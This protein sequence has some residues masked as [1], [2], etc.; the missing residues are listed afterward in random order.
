MTTSEYE[1]NEVVE[2]YDIIRNSWRRWKWWDNTIM[3]RDSNGVVGDQSFWN[4]VGPYGQEEIRR[5]KCS[6][7]FVKEMDVD[8][9][10]HELLRL[11]H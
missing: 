1:D 2:V 9:T 8:Q 10:G 4:A 6:L 11:A 3:K 7:T 5:V